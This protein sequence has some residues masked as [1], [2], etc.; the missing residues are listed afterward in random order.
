MAVSVISGPPNSGRAVR[1]RE[2][3]EACL[4]RDPV[5]VVPTGDDAARFER[6]LCES[7][8]AVLGVSIRTFASLF[9]DVARAVAVTL[10]PPLSAPE[11]L[12]LLGA[13]IT[14]TPLRLLARSAARSGFG[15]ALDS[16]IRELQGAL[17]S[18]AALRAAAAELSDG[19]YE[20]ELAALYATYVELRERA[21]RSDAGSRAEAALARLRRSP[22]SWGERPVFVYGFDDLSEAQLGLIGELATT[23]DVVVSVNYADREALKGNAELLARLTELGA[24]IEA[25]VPHEPGYTERESLRHLDRNLF[26]PGAERVEIDDGVLLLECGGELGEAEAV[27][28]E[29][30]RLLADGVPPDEI[31]VVARDVSR[32]G[33]SLGRILTRLEIPV[34][35]ETTVPLERTAVGRSL[36]ALCRAAAPDGAPTDLLAHLRADPAFA[37]V[38][39]DW[40]ERRIRRA[41]P[42]TVEEAISSWR[43]SPRHLSALRAAGSPPG[44]M[45]AL[46]RVAR[47]LAEAPHLKAAPVGRARSD[48]VPFDPLELRAAALAAELFDEL[49]EIGDLPGCKPPDLGEAAEAIEGAGV[50]TWRGPAEGRVRVVDPYRIR[51]GRARYLFCL[52]LQEG[53]F[54]RRATQHPL[55][56]EERRSQLG[57]PALRRRDPQAEERHLFHACVSRPTER[58]YLSWQVCDD[59]G[60]PL[61]RSPFVD[62]VLDLLGP[63]AE[64]AE[65]LLVRRRGL[66]RVAFSP[67]EA[68]TEHELERSL[69]LA[70]P[71]QKEIRPGPL[72]SEAVLAELGARGLVSASSLEGWMEC[73]YRWFV[74]H[75]LQPQRLDPEPDP[76]RL[77][78]VAH[79]TLQRLYAEPPGTD[80]IPRPGDVGRWKSRLAELLAEEAAAADMHPDDPPDSIA[81][82]RL[83]AQIG[84]FLEEEA[85]LDTPMRPRPDLLEVP[86]GFD[87]EGVEAL[88]LGDIRLRGQIDRVDVAPDGSVA[89]VRD[90]KTSKEMPGRAT[91]ERKGKLQLQ[92]Y[93]LAAR[94][95]LG[96][97][98]IGGLYHA[99]GAYKERRP[100]GMVI[101]GDAR[102]GELALVGGDACDADAFDAELERAREAAASEAQAM[103]SGA[104]ARDPINDRCPTYCAYQAICR[105]ER[106]VGLDEENGNGE[107][108]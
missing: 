44:R 23:S 83:R 68:P 18:P 28:G 48:G 59:E 49:A 85:E 54:P 22:G 31:T 52:G 57:I 6:E 92:L 69:A 4:D 88:D 35:V 105:L 17:V 19:D 30:A 33:P 25:P 2:R 79:R 62:E 99:L 38:H 96:L 64:T 27:G 11:R 107:G 100:R 24:Q 101:A 51:A 60:R 41:R 15:P 45:R 74:D 3:L 16:L 67:E 108:A 70:G 55:L 103:R 81:L 72:R 73:S 37:R 26:E 1:V 47:E 84:R 5:L 94:E 32:R 21:G 13:A 42:A 80:A 76:L 75:E 98:P 90:Y 77:G 12:A 65:S 56:S 34:A 58:L 14:A 9:E 53:E 10:P 50:P 91:W 29:I 106:A 86:F 61:A 104:I 36:L 39:A 7:A 46:A 20:R 102:L 95:R 93:V 89:V 78:T 40:L 71:R 66:E 97:D 82:S 8:G 87:E 43:T 63:D